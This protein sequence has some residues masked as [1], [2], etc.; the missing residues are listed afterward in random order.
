MGL[1]ASISGLVSLVIQV[2]QMSIDYVSKVSSTSKSQASYIQELTAIQSV[3]G[4]FRNAG[5]AGNVDDPTVGSSG[6]STVT[7]ESYKHQITKL[8]A[9][10]EKSLARSGTLSALRALTWPFEESEMGGVVD[11]LHRLQ[12]LLHS[13]LTVERRKGV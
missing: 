8:K 5:V 7:I 6:I 11:M 10:L 3:L 4:R 12:C 2:S 1:A 13:H 9:K